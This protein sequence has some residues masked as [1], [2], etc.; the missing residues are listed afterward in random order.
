MSNL[1]HSMVALG[2]IIPLIIL[3]VYLMKR[4]S[5]LPRTTKNQPLRIVSQLSLGSK[6]HITIVETDD[7]Q[8]IVGV[9]P[10]HMDILYQAER[11]H[12]HEHH[13]EKQH[14]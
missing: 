5:T 11:P 13:E 14:G 2:I 9:S 6:H 3:L 7:V 4:F 8:L 1:L 12:G 10:N